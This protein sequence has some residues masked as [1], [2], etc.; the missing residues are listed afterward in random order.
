MRKAAIILLLGIA[1]CG[2]GAGSK[3]VTETIAACDPHGGAA[4]VY[5]DDR[6]VRATC[7]NGLS[8]SLRNK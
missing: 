2:G 8:I 1:G 3:L 4:W 5:I 7:E 6:T